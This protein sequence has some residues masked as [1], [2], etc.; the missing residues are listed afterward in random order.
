M[1]AEFR[2]TRLYSTAEGESCFEDASVPFD[3]GLAAPPAQPQA[4]AALGDATATFVVHG[5]RNWDGG[6]PHPAP[7]R[8]LF[9]VLR[10]AY[11]VTASDGESRT[12]AQGDVLLVE[13]TTG[14]GHATRSL[15]D[16]TMAQ[17]TRL[18]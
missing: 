8:L 16:D 5:D 4:M 13:D 6:D 11:E 3:E 1:L 15:A 12:F 7:A 17:V 2:F 14:R 18:A 9:T 10:G